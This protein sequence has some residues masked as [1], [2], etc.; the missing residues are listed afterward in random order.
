[1]PA[2]GIRKRWNKEHS[3]VRVNKKLSK[4]KVAINAYL[5]DDG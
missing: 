5:C 4:E 1:M 2:S 3:K